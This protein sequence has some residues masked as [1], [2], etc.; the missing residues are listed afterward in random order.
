M[1][2]VLAIF[3]LSAVTMIA[4]IVGIV[5][6]KPEPFVIASVSFLLLFVWLMYG[7]RAGVKEKR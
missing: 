7:L 4:I 6:F 5:T 1:K 2:V 3:G